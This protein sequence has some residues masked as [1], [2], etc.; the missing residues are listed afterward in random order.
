VVDH[1][2]KLLGDAAATASTDDSSSD[3]CVMQFAG[4]MQALENDP[5]CAVFMS[6]S[7]SGSDSSPF[8]HSANATLEQIDLQ[9]N[10]V[11]SSPCLPKL[12]SLAKDITSC[13][14]A[15]GATNGINLADLIEQLFK[16]L[17]TVKP[18]AVDANGLP[19]YCLAYFGQFSKSGPS[20]DDQTAN[21]AEVCAAYGS[22]GCCLGSVLAFV[23]STMIDIPS[24]TTDPTTSPTITTGDIGNRI[25]DACNLTIVPPPCPDVTETVDVVMLS[26]TINGVSYDYYIKTPENQLTVTYALQQDIAATLGVD[27]SQVSISK[28]TAGSGSKYGL[29]LMASSITVNAVVIPV[30]SQTAAAIQ[31]KAAAAISG[32]TFSTTNVEK[33]P[34]AALDGTVSVSKD[35]TASEGS[36][37][38]VGSSG[39]A[40]SVSLV[41]LVAIVAF[42]L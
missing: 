28:V 19:I 29:H 7:G 11:C 41:G 6:S 23:N 3:P 39:S 4:Q 9:I 2:F 33:L 10:T 30:G 20:D 36:A 12:V 1:A 42:S 27:P 13:E 17:C 16:F 5:D 40:L 25:K 35:S 8:S 32:G 21:M 22:M 37:G 34:A 26:L 38:G 31:A 24:N 14:A 18:G 15:A